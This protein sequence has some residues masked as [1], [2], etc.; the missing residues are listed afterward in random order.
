MARPLIFHRI[1]LA[2]IVSNR[3]TMS[4][5]PRSKLLQLAQMSP[6]PSNLNVE[7][8]SLVCRL[9]PQ[10]SIFIVPGNTIIWRLPCIY[11][12]H[13]S[14]SNC[15]GHWHRSPYC[16]IC[17][18]Q[19]SIIVVLAQLDCRRCCLRI[20]MRFSRFLRS[21]LD[22]SFTPFFILP[23]LSSSI[24]CMDLFNYQRT[25]TLLIVYSQEPFFLMNCSWE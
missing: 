8:I 25:G 24:P 16:S 10:F 3:R 13:I 12:W 22:I 2:R 5:I 19:R 1:L 21:C 15:W 6:Q 9:Y 18:C 11:R 17:N 14:N 20:V 23:L 7:L 4:S